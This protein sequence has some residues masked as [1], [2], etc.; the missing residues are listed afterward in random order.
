[1]SRR[2]TSTGAGRGVAQHGEGFL[3]VARLDRLVTEPTQHADQEPA[4]EGR[5]VDDEDPA[6]GHA[7]APTAST[8]RRV[9]ATSASA[10]H[11]RGDRLGE[12]VVH[13]GGEAALAIVLQRVR[14][15]RHDPGAVDPAR[16]RMRRVASRPS[17]SGIWTSIRTRS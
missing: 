16:L 2:I 7:S 17:S 13:P 6:G 10:Q 9:V 5:V 3:P 12:V 14:G 8:V 4:V 1:M 15:H 11:L